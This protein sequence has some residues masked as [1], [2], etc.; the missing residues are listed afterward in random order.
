MSFSPAALRR[1]RAMAPEMPTV[2][3]VHQLTPWTR[4]TGL[5]PVN[6][7]V[8]P[9]LALLRRV[10]SYVRRVQRAGAQV[11]VWTVNRP[12]DMEFVLALGV[13][14]VITDHPGTLLHRL[15]RDRVRPTGE[16]R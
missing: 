7:A 4:T 2:Q 13:D 11:H 9:S 12:E 8:G 16:S 1:V 15:G 6:T 14:A 10:P 3:L 5:P